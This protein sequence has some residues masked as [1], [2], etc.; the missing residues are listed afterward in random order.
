MG[1]VVGLKTKLFEGLKTGAWLT[2]VII[3]KVGFAVGLKT[4]PEKHCSPE[5]TRYCCYC[6]YCWFRP[7]SE[8]A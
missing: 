6:N 8:R 5:G 4:E 2:S 7:K 3:M 1:A